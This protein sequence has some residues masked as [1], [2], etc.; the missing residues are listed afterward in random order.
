M[1]LV[2]AI[3]LSASAQNVITTV[4]GAPGSFPRDPIS[5]TQAPLGRIDGVAVDRSG[6]IYAS[7][8]DNQI[9][10]RIGT[11]GVTQVVAGNGI[12]GYSGDNGPAIDASLNSPGNLAIDAHNSLFIADIS[13]G[14]IRKVDSAGVIST[15]AVLPLSGQIAIDSAGNVYCSAPNT[16]SR[17]DPSG[18]VTLFAGGGANST[19]QDGDRAIDA[20]FDSVYG[21]AAD[22]AGN[23]FISLGAFSNGSGRTGV[24]RVAPDGTITL[25]FA[26]V[27]GF[28]M[29]ADAAGNVYLPVLNANQIIR[30][31]AAASF[32]GLR[33]SSVYAG[34][35]QQGFAGDGS[36]ASQA[37]LRLQISELNAFNPSVLGLSVDSLGNL[38]FGDL[39]NHRLR[40]VGTDGIIGTTAGN[41]KLKFGGDGGQGISAQLDLP[42]DLAVDERGNLY[43][44]DFNNQRIRRVDASGTITTFAGGG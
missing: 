36:A 11:D 37:L 39:G 6:N 12:A 4:A 19:W 17:V 34:T 10:V 3:A 32:F 13:N 27:I 30:I 20:K 15:L 44:V 23:V 28:G 33:F 31:S 25:A 40:R 41:G 7:D 9:V 2:W 35:G 43:V 16:V 22:G 14:R 1:V 26:G 29:A 5:A 24:A 21:V 42:T 38:Y 18:T 8:L